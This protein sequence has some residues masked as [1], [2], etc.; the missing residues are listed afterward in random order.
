MPET[1]VQ[2]LAEEYYHC[3]EV[4]VMDDEGGL[5]EK[6][7]LH[8]LDGSEGTT[9]VLI[10]WFWC[11]GISITDI[12][13]ALGTDDLSS[14][15]NTASNISTA[16]ESVQLLYEPYEMPVEPEW[17]ELFAAQVA[18]GVPGPDMYL[19]D[20]VEY[21]GRALYNNLKDQLNRSGG[22]D[23]SWDP[24]SEHFAVE[25]LSKLLADTEEELLFRDTVK[26]TSGIGD[27]ISR[28]LL[29]SMREWDPEEN[30]RIEVPFAESARQRPDGDSLIRYHDLSDETDTGS[31]TGTDD[32][33][34]GQPVQSTTLDDF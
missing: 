17:L 13:D 27:I 16:L 19:I 31:D 34:R 8:N 20:N 12:E 26:G 33:D 25:R 32:E 24:D 18:E 7:D 14:L 15:A 22:S 11:A 29:E 10:C 5:N 4:M 6:M 1:L 28:N 21:F 2:R 30:D 23:A 3:D 9:A